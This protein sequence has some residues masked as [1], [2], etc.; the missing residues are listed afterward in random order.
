MKNDKRDLI[1]KLSAIVLFILLLTA[2]EKSDENNNQDQSEQVPVLSTSEVTDITWHSSTCG[3][4]ITSEGSSAVSNRGVCWSM[5]Q[6]PTFQDATSYDGTGGGSFTSYIVHLFPET[7]YHVRAY[8]T[9]SNGTGYG[10]TVSFTTLPEQNYPCPGTPTVSYEN[11][12]YNTVLID[13][14]CWLKENLNI[15]TMINSTENM[16]DNGV[17]EKYC[18]DNDSANC[19][20]Q[21]GLYQWNEVMQYIT[22]QGTRGIC[23]LAWHIPTDDEW[24][25][26]EGTVDSQFPV[27]DPEWDNGGYRGHDAGKNLKTAYG[28][29]GSTSGTN[30]YGF[31]G[32]PGGYRELEGTFNMNGYLA[33]WWTSTESIFGAAWTRNFHFSDSDVN[34]WGLNK[35]YGYSVRCIKD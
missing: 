12:D 34:R 25:I 26:L 24:K 7:K 30:L 15:G 1:F 18:Y 14:Q 13:D 31:S 27:G 5:Q 8:A 17:I 29:T 16:T 10:N 35:E 33:S 19:D 3:G 32:L 21:G 6:N 28:W 9:N 20:T 23:P 2:C 11:Q 22:Q 4:N